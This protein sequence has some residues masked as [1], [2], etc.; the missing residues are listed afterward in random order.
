MRDEYAAVT[1]ERDGPVAIVRLNRPEKRNAMNRAVHAGLVEAFDGL[2]ADDDIR[3]IILTGSGDIAF[4]AGADMTERVAVMDGADLGPAPDGVAAIARCSKP[5]I[6]AINGFAYGGG[7]RLALTTDF[8]LASEN[9]RFRFVGVTYGLVVGATQL[10]WLTGPAIAKELLFTARV[11]ESDEALRL[12]L[13]NH[14]Y[15][16]ASLLAE[17][18]AMGKLIAENSLPAVSWVKKVVNASTIVVEGLKAQEEADAAT[19]RSEDHSARFRE[20]AQ[21]ITGG[22]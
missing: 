12:G 5:V 17:A 4:C 11:V 10:A 6:G 8:R 21:R 2:D 1:C 13:V 19:R 20:A 9:A 16:R 7:A 3:V 15:P 22:R 14:V 18:V